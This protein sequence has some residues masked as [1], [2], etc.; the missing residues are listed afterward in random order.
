MN[1]PNPLASDSNYRR[2]LL[3]LKLKDFD[4]SQKAKEEMEIG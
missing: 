2:D 1:H 3:Y 4:N